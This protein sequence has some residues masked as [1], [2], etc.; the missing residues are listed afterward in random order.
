MTGMTVA[1]IPPKEVSYT[2]PEPCTD[3]TLARALETVFKLVSRIPYL[4]DA[5]CDWWIG[6][7]DVGQNHRFDNLTYEAL[8]PPEWFTTAQKL[9]CKES[10][11]PLFLQAM[12]SY[13]KAEEKHPHVLAYTRYFLD[14]NTSSPKCRRALAKRIET[15]LGNE[16]SIHLGIPSDE[17]EKDRPQLSSNFVAAA[18]PLLEKSEDITELC[19]HGPVFEP[20]REKLIETI[21]KMKHLTRLHFDLDEKS[22]SYFVDKIGVTLLKNSK[23]E[24]VTFNCYSEKPKPVEL[25][26]RSLALLH[27]FKD[28]L[29]FKNVTLPGNFRNTYF[30]LGPLPPL[31][32][33][34]DFI[35]RPRRHKPPQASSS[36]AGV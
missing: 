9:R 17:K 29:V 36:N 7:L 13:D 23:I 12:K 34:K 6:T 11:A 14:D 33:P 15:W 4:G 10:L 31:I 18:C 25:G 35:H 22:T 27:N 19:I 16:G 30:P 1:K 24:K 28:K 21:S 5:I 3:P 2:S 32:N 20:D 26:A 8:Q